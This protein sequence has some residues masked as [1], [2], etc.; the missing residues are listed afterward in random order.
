MRSRVLSTFRNL[1]L[2]VLLIGSLGA[3]SA[4]DLP[5]TNELNQELVSAR[6]QTLRD[7]GSQEGSESTLHSYEQVLDWLGEAEV[8]AATE[9]TYVQS[10]TDAPLEES[11]IRDRMESKDYRAPDLDPAS[12]AKLKKR[13]LD[14][15][16]T[17]LRTKLRDAGTAK[18]ALDEQIVSEQSSAPTIQARFEVIDARSQELPSTVITIQPDLQPSQFEAAQWSD[19][20]E[21]KALGAERRSLEARLASQSVRYSRRKAES[22]EQALILDGLTFEIGILETELASRQEVQESESSISLDEDAA[23]YGFVQQLIEG[24]A[25]LREERTKLDTTLNALKDEDTRIGNQS[26]S[27]IVSKRYCKSCHFRKTVRLSAMC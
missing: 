14:D 7:A 20:A 15:Q 16:L 1:L 11:V 13:D 27:R 23:G 3:A 12:V 8:H 9:K 17:A 25:Q 6:I 21:R 26:L 19:L 24:N 10:L 22:D 18:S 5:G 4:Q 2:L